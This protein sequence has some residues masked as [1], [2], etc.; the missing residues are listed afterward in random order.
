MTNQNFRGAYTTM[1]LSLKNKAIEKNI[2]YQKIADIAGMSQPNVSKIIN[3]IY[4]TSVEN[5]LK[6][7][8]AI[9]SELFEKLIK[10]Q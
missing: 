4:V 1:C 6:I 3:G 5:F 7:A 8:K 2:S 9:D 10:L